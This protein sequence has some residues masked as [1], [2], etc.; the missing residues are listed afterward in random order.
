[1]AKCQT[2]Q[3][4]YC[5][6]GDNDCSCDTGKNAVKLGDSQP[7][8]VTVIGSTSWPGITST[9]APF[10]QSTAIAADGTTTSDTTGDPNTGTSSSSPTSTSASTTGSGTAAAASATSTA[11]VASSGGGSSNT[12]LAA[13]LGAG[14]GAAAVLI[15]V[16]G[17]FL[18]RSRRRKARKAGGTTGY[19]PGN[20]SDPMEQKPFYGASQPVSPY[21]DHHL[22]T[23]GGAPPMPYKPEL[24]GA[25]EYDR[26]EMPTENNT[27]TFTPQRTQMAE[28]PS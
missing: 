26:S 6:P 25:G 4:W 23:A 15:A 10:T 22:N 5:C 18:I 3:D 27:G 19:T 20:G 14:L 13:G 1:M 16:L 11:P 28:L 2:T 9:T 12:G 21:S 7:S 17:F 8:T 24:A